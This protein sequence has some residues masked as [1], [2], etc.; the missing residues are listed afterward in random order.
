MGLFQN[1]QITQINTYP[2]HKKSKN[3][4]PKPKIRSGNW[5]GFVPKHPNQ[6]NTFSS[7]KTTIW[8][9]NWN[10]FVPKHTNTF[11]FYKTKTKTK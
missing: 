4:K 10:G 8:S 3:P 2:S 7:H 5:N 9:E 11:P 1:T 6:T